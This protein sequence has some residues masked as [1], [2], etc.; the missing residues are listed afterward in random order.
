MN[1]FKAWIKKYDFAIQLIKG[2]ILSA[3]L[4]VLLVNCINEVRINRDL[5]LQQRGLE[6]LASKDGCSIYRFYDN[7]WH[8]MSKCQ[9]D[10]TLITHTG[11]KEPTDEEI[12]TYVN[13]E[14]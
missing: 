10:S 13:K 9:S 1:K 4:G 5:T 3:A 11:G 2:G 14:Q 6:Y 8:Y 7:G 12:N